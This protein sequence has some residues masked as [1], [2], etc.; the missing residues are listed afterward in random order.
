M[1]PVL[2][3]VLSLLLAWAPVREVAAQERAPATPQ[4]VDEPRDEPR[5]TPRLT[6]GVGAGTAWGEGG[7]TTL[8]SIQLPVARHLAVEG[9]ATR[10]SYEFGNDITTLGGN[11]LFTVPSSRVSTFVGGGLGVHR[12]T[13]QPV[14]FPIVCAPPDSHACR[15]LV[16]GH[17][18]GI[19]GQAVGGVE[20]GVMSRL[21]AFTTVRVGTAPEEGIRMFAGMRAALLMR[22]AAPRES[23]RPPRADL[24]GR[25]IRVM[26]ADG[27]KQTGRFVALSDTEVTFVATREKTQAT[28]LPLAGV[29]KVETVSHHARTGAIV[30]AG[31][32]GVLLAIGYVG[33]CADC[34][35]RRVGFFFPPIFAGVGAA[36]GGMINVATA[37]RHALYQAS[38]ATGSVSIAP[39][40][41]PRHQGVALIKRW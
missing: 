17:D 28:I 37:N 26:F 1:A 24:A 38:A 20:I 11:L 9:E 15:L 5:R 30:G 10:R 34:E 41:S 2:L 25:E 32:G 12:T 19:V 3:S 16:S 7:P 22:D 13:A 6:V 33:D 14:S 39:I 8:L 31:V 4:I 27:R 23:A 29:R 21:N 36:L 18:S 40:F 35:D